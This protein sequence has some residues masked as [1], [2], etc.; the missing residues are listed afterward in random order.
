MEVSDEA[1]ELNISGNLSKAVDAILAQP[2][3]LEGSMRRSRRLRARRR[4]VVGVGVAVFMVAAAGWISSR[5]SDDAVT[6]EVEAVGDPGGTSTVPIPAPLVP[7]PAPSAPNPVPLVPDLDAWAGFYVYL[8]QELGPTDSSRLVVVF[9]STVTGFAQAEGILGEFDDASRSISGYAPLSAGEMGSYLAGYAETVDARFANVV[10]PIAITLFPRFPTTTVLEDVQD[11]LTGQP[12]IQHVL[13]F[14]IDQPAQVIPSE[15]ELF[16]AVGFD[17]RRPAVFQAVGN[18]LIIWSEDGTVIA[19]ADTVGY[20]TDSGPLGGPKDCCGAHL[21]AVLGGQ[22]VVF[23]S[24]IG[25]ATAM[26]DPASRLWT[27]LADRPVEGVLVGATVLGEEV[28]V[29]VAQRRSNVPTRVV[30]LDLKANTW[31][32]LEPIP[33]AIGSGSVVSAYG[34][35]LVIGT[36]LG[37]DNLPSSGNDRPVL[38]ELINDTWEQRISPPIDPASTS[39]IA[40]ETGEVLAWSYRNEAVLLQPGG[41]WLE[42]SS[43][44]IQPTG[45]TLQGHSANNAVL[46]E[47]CGTLVRYEPSSQQFTVIPRA[48]EQEV[49]LAITNSSDSNVF[50]VTGISP[51]ETQIF[52]LAT[53]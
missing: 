51:Q 33:A 41:D 31:R 12:A 18:Q 8:Q 13:A 53:P 26:F 19:S 24:D 35:L 14:D 27:A 40:L 29:V 32:I 48:S 15:W 39:A 47:G 4:L 44:P 34:R 37:D 38:Y 3:L 50:A 43:I 9:D 28:V 23:E 11:L 2:E 6:F 10:P 49:I 16:A 52:K 7:D 1:S 17:M 45:C 21:S 20:S 46:L 22:L 30:A 5:L 42:L 25:T 36:L